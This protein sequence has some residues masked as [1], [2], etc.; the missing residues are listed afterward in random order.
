M[1]DDLSI[2]Y[3]TVFQ[4]QSLG[5]VLCKSDGEKSNAISSSEPSEVLNEYFGLGD[6]EPPIS[7]AY[8]ALV[9]PQ[10]S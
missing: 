5:N 10:S 7:T 1:R 3:A 9:R 6:V 2:D 8:T 4:T